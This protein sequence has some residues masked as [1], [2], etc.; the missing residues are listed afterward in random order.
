M[1]V[2]VSRG[3]ALSALLENKVTGNIATVRLKPPRTETI[4]D[5]LFQLTGNEAE[6]AASATE[7]DVAP[8]VTSRV[9]SVAHLIAMKVLAARD[10]D[11]EDLG[12]LL[13]VASASDLAAAK[14]ALA[15]IQKA[16]RAPG[17]KLVGELARLL[18]PAPRRPRRR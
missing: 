2:F 11:R 5:L 17:R 13:R 18:A 9:A 12:N 4:V 8:G 1:Q 14:R 7:L 3:F 16:G 6:I 15:Q 10:K